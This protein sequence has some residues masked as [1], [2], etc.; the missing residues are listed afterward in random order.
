M[1]L[2]DLFE[3]GS[4]LLSGD[5]AGAMGDVRDVFGGGPVLPAP[6][7]YFPQSVSFGA[8]GQQEYPGPSYPVVPVRSTAL[9]TIPPRMLSRYPALS[10]WLF[11]KNL[12]WYN[13]VNELSRMLRKWGP[14]ALTGLLGIQVVSELVTHSG[15][16]KRRRMNPAN[17]RAL[18]RSLRR[19]KSFDRLSSRVKAQL[20]TSCHRPRRKVC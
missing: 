6:S 15:T 10:K 19:L 11:E 2:F 9:A 7:G 1:G 17:S 5:Y 16:R 14:T 3:L 18:R 13:G 20:A 12:S 8:Y 4:D